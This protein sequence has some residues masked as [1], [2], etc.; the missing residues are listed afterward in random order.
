M[1]RCFQVIV[2]TLILSSCTTVAVDS[3]DSACVADV[4]IA[5]ELTVLVQSISIATIDSV[6]CTKPL[7]SDWTLK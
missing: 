3:P 2:L 6:V 7:P 1:N 4:I 5:G